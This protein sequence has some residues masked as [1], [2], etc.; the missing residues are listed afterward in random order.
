MTYLLAALLVIVIAMLGYLVRASRTLGTKLTAIKSSQIKQLEELKSL[1][2]EHN[3]RMKKLSQ[4]SSLPVVVKNSGSLDFVV[5][6]TSHGARFSTLAHVL[7]RLRNQVLQ[8]QSIQLNIASNEMDSL[9]AEVKALEKDG[10]ITIH[11]C[12]DLGPA[13]KLIPILQSNPKLPVIVIDDDL[14]F[15][16]ELFLHLVVTHNLYPC[17][18]IASR[19]HQ[20]VR[21]ENGQVESFSNWKKQYSDSEGPQADLMP[22]SGS[23]TL[24]PPGAFHA[25]VTD[26]AQYLALAKNTDD[27]WWYFQARRAGTL[28]RRIDGFSDLNFVGETQ[29]VGLWK[30]GNKEKNEANLAALLKKYGDPLTI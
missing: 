12:N 21:N 28:V 13:K 10:F 20:L 29:A 25:D 9:P 26:E 3:R 18:I 7:N 2:A 8:P 23:G 5:S 6:L 14:D 15:D 4:L 24:F 30:N 11:S 27:L 22:T 17:A 19:V 1:S 16:P